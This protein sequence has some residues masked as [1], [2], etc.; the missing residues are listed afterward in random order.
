M[1]YVKVGEDEL[2]S[3]FK[4]CNIENLQKL[5]VALKLIDAEGK[6]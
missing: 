4:Y 2:W 1:T 5:I 3:R 6:S